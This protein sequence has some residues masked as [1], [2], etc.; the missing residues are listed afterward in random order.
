MNEEDFV[1][2]T[3]ARCRERHPRPLL[4]HLRY[5][6]VAPE[7]SDAKLLYARCGTLDLDEITHFYGGILN[8]HLR[9]LRL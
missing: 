1:A 7:R 5:F 4:G 2:H 8:L 3:A 9:N 6:L